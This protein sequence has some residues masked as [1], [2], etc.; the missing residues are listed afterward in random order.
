MSRNMSTG[1]ASTL[2]D[3]WQGACE[4]WLLALARRAI[5]AG[6][7]APGSPAPGPPDELPGLPALPESCAEAVRAP[8]ATFVTLLIEGEL[9]G[10]IGTFEATGP[11]AE[12]VWSYAQKAAFA[13]PRFPPLSPAELPRL[14]IHIAILSAPAPMQVDSREALVQQLV[15]GRD[16][17]VIE[18]GAAR[19]T[20]LP[21]VW[22][23]LP[24]AEE[25]VAE[26]MRK[27]GL[28][29]RHWSDSTRA[30]RYRSHD[31]PT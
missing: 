29:A 30:L 10:C 19:A 28:P 11:L 15:P 27:A 17:L 21:S 16:G 2:P 14:E 3:G 24:D 6:L 4:E 8:R 26:L 18:D 20:F 13:D 23:S 7:E 9:R 1:R 22:A 5:E 25:F 31:L 12:A